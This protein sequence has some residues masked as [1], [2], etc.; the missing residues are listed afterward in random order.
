M[1]SQRG[2]LILGGVILVVLAGL[3]LWLYSDDLF[4]S[5]VT[6]PA[7][8]AAAAANARADDAKAGAEGSVVEPR[9]GG[10]MSAPRDR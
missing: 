3:M 9:A 4:S 7:K 6:D 8:S 10:R 5:G 2:R 1:D